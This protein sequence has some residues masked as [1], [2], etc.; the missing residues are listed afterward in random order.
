M[1]GF[2]TQVEG[3]ENSQKACHGPEYA[4]DSCQSHVSRMRVILQRGVA[5]VKGREEEEE[6]K[7]LSL[8]LIYFSFLSHCLLITLSL[9]FYSPRTHSPQTHVNNSCYQADPPLQTLPS[10]LRI[11]FV[12]HFLDLP[13]TTHH[14]NPYHPN[15]INLCFST[16]DWENEFH[17]LFKY[18]VPCT[19][20]HIPI[21]VCFQCSV[22]TEFKSL[23]CSVD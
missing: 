7:A 15:A 21:P 23:L 10:F 16:S 20:A 22:K 1:G 18:T 6:E 9:T 12:C 3:R 5:V 14:P 11:L 19:H 13:P 8:V 2:Q 17:V 4:A